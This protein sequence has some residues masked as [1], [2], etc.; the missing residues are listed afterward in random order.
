M[1]KVASKTFT[2]DLLSEGSWGSRDL[3]KHESTMDLYLEETRGFIEWDV[4]DLDTTEEIG[5]MF[6]FRPGHEPQLQ[7][8]DY[9]GV[10]SLPDEAIELIE[11][12]GIFVPNE[13]KE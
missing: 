8:Y 9:D 12:V 2:T 6:E 11:S 10:F 4:P 1:R 5:L 13:F 3:G 7:L